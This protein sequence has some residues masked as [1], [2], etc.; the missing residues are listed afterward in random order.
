MNEVLLAMRFI[1]KICIRALTHVHE[2]CSVSY[3]FHEK[4]DQN[5]SFL[6]I[7]DVSNTCIF[8]KNLLPSTEFIVG[9]Y[10][11]HNLF[12]HYNYSA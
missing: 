3:L 1:P 5:S 12:S 10:L 6:V 7:P 11:H 8:F 4:H 9:V 2:L